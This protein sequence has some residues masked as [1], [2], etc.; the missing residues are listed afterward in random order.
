MY[1]EDELLPISALQHMV[2]CARRCALVHIEG[3][4]D[5]NRYTVEGDILHERVHEQGYAVR[6]GIRI[7]RGVPLRSLHLGL[8]GKADIVEFEDAGTPKHA[9]A[10]YPIEYKRGKPKN[11]KAYEVQLCAQALCLEEM[12]DINVPCGALFYGQT[13]RRVEIA[14]DA[15]VRA[16]TKETAQR[17]H[18]LLA[19]GRTPPAEYGKKCQSCS[20]SA[21]CM[22][23]PMSRRRSAAQYNQTA[24]TLETPP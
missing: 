17:A 21:W 23:K 24:R 13:R 11:N 10:A 1:T 14:I 5:E 6:A 16:L 22:P 8:S 7:A 15:E 9:V 12:L 19:S 20:L 4:W 18:D 2:F 3:V